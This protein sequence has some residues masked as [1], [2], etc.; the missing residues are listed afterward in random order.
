MENRVSLDVFWAWICP[1]VDVFGLTDYGQIVLNFSLIVYNPSIGSVGKLVPIDGFL[2]IGYLEFFFLYSFKISV[3]DTLFKSNSTI[4][5]IDNLTSIDSLLA[6]SL[7]SDS[8][9]RFNFS[10][11]RLI[12]LIMA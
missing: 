12:F 5:E 6:F 7:T 11:I 10:F 1:N 2:L 4:S 9:L 3:S 8:I